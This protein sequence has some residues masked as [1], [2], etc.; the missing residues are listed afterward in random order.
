MNLT[1]IIPIAEGRKTRSGFSEIELVSEPSEWPLSAASRDKDSWSFDH[2]PLNVQAVSEIFDLKKDSLYTFGISAE[3][4]QAAP[5][6]LV[7][8]KAGG[9]PSLDSDWVK[10]RPMG[11]AGP[12]EI[13]FSHTPQETGQFQLALINYYGS[14][15]QGAKL[16]I[17]S[18]VCRASSYVGIDMEAD[19]IE[20]YLPHWGGVKRYIH[21]RCRESRIF[22][23]FVAAL[24]MRLDREECL[25]L[26]MYLSMC[27]TG[28]CN[29]LCD[30]C[31]VTIKRTGIIKKQLSFDKLNGFLAPTLNTAYMYGVEGNGEPTLYREFNSLLATLQKRGAASYLITNGA[32]IEPEQ[33]PHLLT[34]QSITFS[35]NAATAETH[36]KVMKLKEFDRVTNTIRSIVDQRGM[37]DTPCVFVSFVVHNI[38]AHELQDFLKFAE[39]DLRVN[40]IMIRPLSELGVDTG[41]VEDLRDIVPYECQIRDALDAAAEYL[42]DVQRRAIPNTHFKCDIRLDPSTFRSVRPDPLDRVIMPPGYEGRLLAPRR[43]DWKIA[44]SRLDVG[45]H[46]NQVSLKC[47]DGP[48][49]ILWSSCSTP[50]TP[51]E[52]IRFVIRTRL[53]GGLIN[54]SIDDPERGSVAT[55]DILPSSDWR[56]IAVELST[57]EATRLSLALSGTGQGFDADIDFLRLLTPGAGIRK[58]FKLPFP[59]RWQIDTPGVNA[60]WHGNVLDISAKENLHGRYLFKSY[61]NPCPPRS[62]LR[63]PISLEV[64]SGTLVIGI[65]SEDFQKWTH[66]FPFSVGSWGQELQ[67]D[68]G[69]NQRLQV[70]LFARGNDPLSARIDWGD[71]LELTPERE[72]GQDEE[73]FEVPGIEPAPEVAGGVSS[74][75]SQVAKASK[76]KE[77][78]VKFYC[79][80]PWTDINNFTVDGRMDVC[81]ITTGASQEHYALG[82]ILE[83]DFQEIWNG[84]QMREFRRTVNSDTP[85][86]PCQRCP[87]AYGYQGPFF[88]RNLADAAIRMKFDDTRHTGYKK[89][90][91]KSLKQVSKLIVDLF[92]KGF[93]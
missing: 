32:M 7:L 28:Q 36:K 91:A 66:Q 5:F 61:S 77:K 16:R 8:L 30:F 19:A 80:K 18:L 49:G 31:S 33:I 39:Y 40:V 54:L 85:L 68:T 57:G 2:V 78:K 82:N 25:S 69:E 35:L 93:R 29:A 14:Y 72:R 60:H 9:N 43:N 67:I 65:L 12:V 15:T 21:R 70:V 37:L 62:V 74:P 87:M 76:T 42:G 41:A 1:K 3:V 89:L 88:D 20:T 64:H 51:G 50:V 46:M 86:P 17:K 92:F 11:V 4:E 44:D 84:E 81:C 47:P 23:A 59:R 22:N 48:K 83:Q 52:T 6:A 38:N 58:E 27:P 63:L 79:Q 13:A 45:W 73:R 26:P 24:E 90:A 53:R 55:I 10:V 34:L 75:V 56:D 71:T